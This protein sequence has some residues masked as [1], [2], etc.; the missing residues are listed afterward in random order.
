MIDIVYIGYSDPAHIGDVA[1]YFRAL[2]AAREQDELQKLLPWWKRPSPWWMLVLVPISY[3]ALF[4]GIAPRIEVYIT[5]M[6]GAQTGVWADTTDPAVQAAAAKLITGM[7]LQ[8]LLVL[9]IEVPFDRHG[10]ARVMAITLIAAL[11][12]LGGLLGGMPAVEA[13]TQAYM[14]D[15][16]DESSRPRFFLLAM[17]LMLISAAVGP[18]MGSLLISKTHNVLSVFYFG[19]ILHLL[20]LIITL[21]VLPESVSMEKRQRSKEIYL[22]DLHNRS[23]GQEDQD[24]SSNGIARLHRLLPFL[25]S[26][27]V[28]LPTQEKNRNPLRRIKRD[29]SLTLVALGYGDA[30]TATVAY[31]FKLQYAVAIFHWDPVDMGYYII[32]HRQFP[33][34]QYL[35]PKP[36]IIEIQDPSSSEV[37]KKEVHSP[38]FDLT[39]VKAS[40][41][42]N[43]AVVFLY[44]LTKSG[45]VFTILSMIGSFGLGFSPAVPSAAIALYTRQG[46]VEVGTLFGS[47]GCRASDLWPTCRILLLWSPLRTYCRF[48]PACNIFCGCCFLALAFICIAAIRV[49]ENDGKQVAEDN[50]GESDPLPGNQ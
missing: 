20:L 31:P 16:T 38:N 17:A 5:C 2:A 6:S 48:S 41:G 32:C 29:W 10:R 37:I 35:I 39:V 36:V 45:L 25:W 21:F 4:A 34:R 3:I 18:T 19:G 15:V 43:V 30:A 1:R 27:A 14:A 33:Q 49:R 28:F 44:G 50:L 13:A 26:L 46:G 22:R 23:S 24:P 12:R 42:L 47:L 8:A 7:F 9:D 11:C 40:L